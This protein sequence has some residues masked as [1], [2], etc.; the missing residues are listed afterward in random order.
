MLN[1]Y[2]NVLIFSLTILP[3]VL[4]I[5]LVS[6]F[7][8][9]IPIGDD[10]DVFLGYLN[11]SSDERLHALFAQHNEHRLVFNRLIAELIYQTFNQIDFRLLILIGNIS[12]VGIFYMLYCLFS[13]TNIATKFFIPIPY[14]L[15]FSPLWGNE[16]WATASLQH[17]SVILFSLSSLFLFNK[18]EYFPFFCAF[19]FAIAAAYTSGSGLFIFVVLILWSGMNAFFPQ[20]KQ[21]EKAAASLSHKNDGYIKFLLTSSVTAIVFYFYFL[22]YISPSHHP[23]VISALRNP[24]QSLQYFFTFM[25]SFLP[26]TTDLLALACGL[27]TTTFFIYLT[28]K[29]YYYKNSIVYF[30]MVFLILNALAAMI[31]RSGFGVDQAL[32]SKYAIFSVLILISLYIASLESSKLTHHLTAKTQYVFLITLFIMSIFSH[33]KHFE[34]LSTKWSKLQVGV[35]IWR[36]YKVGLNYPDQIRATS[37]IKDAARLGYYQLPKLSRK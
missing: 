15:F 28:Y 17:Y 27:T 29:K 36:E 13:N 31:S 10:Y 6:T 24:L 5:T 7:S 1:R 25:G 34:K 19:L 11:Q 20:P 33:N 9:N 21:S 35:S 18:K 26:F 4:Y 2:R 22:N 14:F 16:T 3:L 32:S 23:S 30:F 8:I 37:L 12:L